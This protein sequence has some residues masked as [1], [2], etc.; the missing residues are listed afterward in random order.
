MNTWQEM[1][2]GIRSPP[3]FEAESWPPNTLP[4]L[5][6][7]SIL[8]TQPRAQLNRTSENIV[9]GLNNDPIGNY[10]RPLKIIYASVGSF[11][12]PQQNVCD[13]GRDIAWP[14]LAIRWSR[15]RDTKRVLSGDTR[16]ARLLRSA[17][18]VARTQKVLVGVDFSDAL[19]HGVRYD[20]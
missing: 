1:Y 4:V 5:Q 16:A 6:T 8:N 20:V 9:W 17:C 10:F 12:R 15:D 2:A 19:C 7:C 3:A 13:Y 11:C 14:L 18:G